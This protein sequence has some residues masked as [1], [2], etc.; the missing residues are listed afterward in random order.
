MGRSLEEINSTVSFDSEAN[1]F[2]KF[3]MYLGP[4]LLVAVGYMDQVTGLHLWLAGHNLD[5]YYYLLF[6]YQV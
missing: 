3:L 6:Y 5:I 1:A 2:R 4:G